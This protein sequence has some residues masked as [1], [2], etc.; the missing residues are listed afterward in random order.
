M[1]TSIPSGRTD[2]RRTTVTGSLPSPHHGSSAS[3][4][5]R[6]GRDGAPWMRHRGETSTPDAAA[7]LLAGTLASRLLEAVEV[8][9]PA[10]RAVRPGPH[11]DGAAVAVEG[12][13]LAHVGRRLRRP[14]LEVRAPARPRHVAAGHDRG[15]AAALLFRP[16]CE[17]IA[18]IHDDGGLR[19]PG[20]RAGHGLRDAPARAGGI[21]RGAHDLPSGRIRD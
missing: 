14:D 17:R 6:P 15:A 3:P 19:G 11:R 16:D 1:S 5:G 21:A 8:D 13:L 4:A 12:E 2:A 7:H 10:R 9:V 18:A 20:S